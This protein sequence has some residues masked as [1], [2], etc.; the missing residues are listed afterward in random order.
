MITVIILSVLRPMEHVRKKSV[1][2]DFHGFLVYLLDN[3]WFG[4]AGL[5]A[6]PSYLLFKNPSLA[7]YSFWK[8][9]E[10]V[11]FYS[12]NLMRRP[13]IPYLS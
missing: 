5:A 2:R 1:C 7:L 13:F 3:F 10:V 11:I 6:S 9:V 8:C 4:L 12:N